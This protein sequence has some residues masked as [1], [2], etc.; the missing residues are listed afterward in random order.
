MQNNNNNNNNNGN[1]NNKH[2]IY[3]KYKYRKSHNHSTNCYVLT[4]DQLCF[5][6][7]ISVFFKYSGYFK[8][9]YL[10]FGKNYGNFSNPI[11]L[12]KISK[13]EFDAILCYLE[14]Q[15]RMQMVPITVINIVN[16]ENVDNRENDREFI[17]LRQ[18]IQHLNINKKTFI[19]AMNH[20]E[21]SFDNELIDQ[22][23]M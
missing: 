19:E 11:F 4:K 14:Y 10:L 21:I 17:M 22:I 23:Y 16:V 1:N 9:N 20:L 13:K 2:H 18:H 12:Q 3:N 7:N 6:V 5:S 8:K 15:H